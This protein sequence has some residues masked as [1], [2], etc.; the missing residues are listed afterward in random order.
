MKS[1]VGICPQARQFRNQ[2]PLRAKRAA[3]AH[4]AVCEAE[5]NVN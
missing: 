5:Q 1:D 2:K 3:D 4:Y